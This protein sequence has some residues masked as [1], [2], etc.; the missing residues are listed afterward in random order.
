MANLEAAQAASRALA[1]RLG[2][3]RRVNGVGIAGSRPNFA[4]RVN[5]VDGADRPDLPDEIEGVP[6]EVKVVG[7]IVLLA[8]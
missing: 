5:L 2:D 4:V 3:D 6:V 7:Q 8:Q 1:C